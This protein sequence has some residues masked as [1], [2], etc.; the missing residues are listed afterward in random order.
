[1]A[2]FPGGLKLA[3]TIMSPFWILLELRVMEAVVATG[4]INRRAKLQSSCYHQQTM[5]IFTG[6]MPFLLPNQQCGS[7]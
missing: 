3:G 7:T 6:W 1:M 2:I 4:D 5:Q